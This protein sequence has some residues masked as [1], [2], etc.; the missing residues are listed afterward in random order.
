MSATDCCL[1]SR[2][3]TR[4][5]VNKELYIRSIDRD[6]RTVEIF[7]ET[8]RPYESTVE[9]VSMG[10]IV[11]DGISVRHASPSVANNFAVHLVDSNVKLLRCDVSS[12]TGSGIGVEAG[13]VEILEC[14]VQMCAGHGI[15]L[16]SNIEG[17]TGNVHVT[18]C[19]VKSN[20]RNGILIKGAGEPNI[21]STILRGNGEFGISIQDSGPR[22]NDNKFQGNAKGPVYIDSLS[23]NITEESWKKSNQLVT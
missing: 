3:Q 22:I 7:W 21:E 14:T 13:N 8:G 10:P 11:L 5:I 18:S 9:C 1:F 6:P 4:I 20:K 19:L 2:Y 17:D 23:H 16:V 12:T 15:V